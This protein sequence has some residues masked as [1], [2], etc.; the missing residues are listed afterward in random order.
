MNSRIIVLTKPEP[1]QGHT[2]RKCT[3]TRTRKQVGGRARGGRTYDISRLKYCASD[4]EE[5]VL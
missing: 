5:L 3:R 2:A 1:V 4:Q